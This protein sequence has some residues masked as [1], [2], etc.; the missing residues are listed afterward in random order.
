MLAS[1][2]SGICC[3]IVEFYK[4]K[5]SIQENKLVK[6]LDNAVGDNIHVYR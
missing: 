3:Y 6:S 5:W 1:S 2:F 4:E